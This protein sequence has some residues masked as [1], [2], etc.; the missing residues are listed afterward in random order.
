MLLFGI[1]AAVNAWF[2]G[3]PGGDEAAALFGSFLVGVGGYIAILGFDRA[4]GRGDGAD[5]PPHR[6]SDPGSID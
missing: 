5:L 4:D 1:I 2:S 6:Q 3:T